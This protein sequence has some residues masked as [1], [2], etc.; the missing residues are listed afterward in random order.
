MIKILPTIL[1]DEKEAKAKRSS[2][3]VAHKLQTKSVLLRSVKSV[4]DKCEKK[5]KTVFM[6]SYELLLQLCVVFMAK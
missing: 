4:L 2:S 6:C 3:F 5:E 1:F